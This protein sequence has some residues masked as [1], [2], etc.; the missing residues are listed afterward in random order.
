ME[1]HRTSVVDGASALSQDDAEVTTR[2]RPPVFIE[3]TLG[4][5]IEPTAPV[6]RDPTE[7]GAGDD[8]PIGAVGLAPAPRPVASPPTLATSRTINRLAEMPIPSRRRLIRD[9]RSVRR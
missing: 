6:T 8:W 7:E 1:H 4:P 5:T 3:R 2:T 9:P